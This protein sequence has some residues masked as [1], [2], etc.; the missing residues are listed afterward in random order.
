[1]KIEALK[2]G[3]IPLDNDERIL[4]V[5]ANLVRSIN[6]FP[7]DTDGVRKERNWQ[8]QVIGEG[9]IVFLTG[10]RLGAEDVLSKINNA[11]DIVLAQ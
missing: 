3:M 5:Q 4:E 10:T 11:I 8:V 9:H 1:M 2:N 6:V 7:P